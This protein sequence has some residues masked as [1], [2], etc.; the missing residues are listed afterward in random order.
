MKYWRNLYLIVFLAVLSISSVA[1][2]GTGGNKNDYYVIIKKSDYSLTVYNRNHVWIAKY[3]VVFGSKDLGDKMVAGDRKTPEGIFHI[4]S[5]KVHSKWCRFL[6]LDYPN[7]E[8]YA[9]FNERKAKG[10]ISPHAN[11][12]GGIGIHGTWP[13]EDFAVDGYQAWTEGCIST[14]NE[15]IIELYNLL[16]VGTTVIIEP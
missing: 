7:A 5:K 15:Y 16:P 11:I 9:K 6:A 2:I 10:V 8:S 4:C 14:K 13:H 1:F 3:P 12:G